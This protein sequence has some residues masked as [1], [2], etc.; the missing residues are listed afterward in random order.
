M[1]FICEAKH[2]EI[3]P[4]K[5][6]YI[7]SK[8]S[9][10][11]DIV[12]S[13]TKLLNVTKMTHLNKLNEYKHYKGGIYYSLKTVLLSGEEFMLYVDTKENYWLRPLD[14]FFED[15]VFEGKFQPRFRKI[16]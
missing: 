9:L 11:V 6:L 15:G 8:D 13:E 5:C 16:G 14:M 10:A 12:V 2:T 1:F 7:Y 3:E 4:L